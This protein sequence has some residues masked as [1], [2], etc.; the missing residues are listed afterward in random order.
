MH[1]C[2][3]GSEEDH[4]G[5]FNRKKFVVESF[6]GF[7]NRLKELSNDL[8]KIKKDFAKALL[9]QESDAPHETLLQ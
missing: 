6:Q 8:Q 2:D 5:H 3:R 1:K 7:E 4:P 9:I